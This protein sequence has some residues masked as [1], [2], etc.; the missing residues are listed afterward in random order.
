M[1]I[2][3]LSA[4]LEDW[5][6]NSEP[7][8][9]ISSGTGLDS[10]YPRSTGI[11]NFAI[12]LSLHYHRTILI[13]HG[14]LVMHCLDCISAS[15]RDPFSGVTGDV[16]MSLLKRDLAAARDMHYVISHILQA[17]RGFLTQTA[18]WWTCNYSGKCNFGPTMQDW[19]INSANQAFCLS[20]HLFGLWLLSGHLPSSTTTINLGM[21]RSEIAH[22][23]QGALNNLEI[24]GGHSMLS[25]KAYQRLQR[26]FDLLKSKGILSAL[27]M[28]ICHNLRV[29]YL[30]ISNTQN[31]IRRQEHTCQI[32]EAAVRY[33][34]TIFNYRITETWIYPDM[35]LMNSL[36][37]W[38]HKICWISIWQAPITVLVGLGVNY[39]RNFDH[40]LIL[41]QYQ[42]WM[43][44]KKQY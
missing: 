37:I 26:F 10:W 27:F 25:S 20:L 39:R 44:E 41:P 7:F 6:Q 19:K 30:L 35:S 36:D 13:I 42:T 1:V 28:D 23:L 11:E 15:N 40:P 5:H 4:R 8:A 32:L 21:E 33:S 16:I 34:M 9:M 31:L 3:G 18:S 24:M 43:K 38:V 17:K 22:L 2:M 12:I 14:G 29:L